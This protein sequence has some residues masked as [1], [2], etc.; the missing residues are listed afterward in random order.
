MFRQNKTKQQG[1]M[2]RE[3]DRDRDRQ[4]HTYRGK[5]RER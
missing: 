5:G 4:T 3:W 2:R 1:A